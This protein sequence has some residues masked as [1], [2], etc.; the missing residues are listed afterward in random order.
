MSSKLPDM[1]KYE[2]PQIRELF[3]KNKIPLH[4]GLT[5]EEI[6]K[7]EEIYDIKF[8]RNLKTMLMDFCPVQA[9]KNGWYNW[10]DFSQ[11]NIQ[12][13]KERIDWQFEGLL[14]DVKENDFWLKEWGQVPDNM[15]ERLALAKVNLQQ[16]PKLVPICGHRFTTGNVETKDNP[17]FSVYQADVIYYGATLLEYFSI[18]FEPSYEIRRNMNY[19]QPRGINPFWEA[20][21]YGEYLDLDEIDKLD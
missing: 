1:Q 5:S 11:E 10:F 8:P 2:I 15:N 6:R 19:S 12:R 16:V 4:Q 18:E 7:C 20:I 21:I 14:F 13:I 17:V 3:E 9:R